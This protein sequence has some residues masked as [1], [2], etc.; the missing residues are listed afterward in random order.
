V[1]AL[2]LLTLLL[3]SA[4]WASEVATS[5]ADVWQEHCADTQSAGGKKAG[6]SFA[7][8]GTA[9]SEVSEELERKPAPE[10][11]YWRG[12]LGGCL[13]RADLADEDLSAFI[14]RVGDDPVYASQVDEARRRLLR[15]MP[16]EPARKRGPG[17]PGLIAGI[18]AGAGAGG[19]FGLA[20]SQYEGM[21]QT[22]ATAYGGTVTRDQFVGLQAEGEGYA[23]RTNLFLGLGAGLAA[24]S[25][26]ILVVSGV[27]Q[28]A[29]AVSAV[30]APT[31]DG[32]A[33]ALGG[34]W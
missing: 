25:A 29:P 22:Y 14:Q 20:G 34:R 23:Q 33:L 5:A 15:S 16:A 13:G 8:V 31:A 21:E 3:P 11:L 30:L 2:L 12:L 27:A 4:A 26:A 17:V 6:A 24:T 32:L 18:A 10:L 7:A 28:R 1:R 9:F 19:V